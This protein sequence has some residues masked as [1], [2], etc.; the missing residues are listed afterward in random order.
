VLIW[1]YTAPNPAV[2]PAAF[3][4]VLLLMSGLFAMG[5]NVK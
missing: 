4:T 5:A 2:V 3:S 1:L